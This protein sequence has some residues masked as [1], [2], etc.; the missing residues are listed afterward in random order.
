MPDAP[1]LVEPPAEMFRV[2]RL[3]PALRYSRINAEDAAKDR[4]G[5]RFDVPGG[6][7]L[8]AATHARGGLAETL[9]NFR[10]SASVARRVARTGADAAESVAPEL[11]AAWRANR[12]IRTLRVNDPLP[13]IDIESASTHTYLT[14]H[15]AHVLRSVEL[16]ALDV[17]AVRGPSRRLTRGL[18]T[19]IYQTQSAD[20][21]PLYGGI[22]Y[23]SRLGDYE[24]WAIFE[25]ADD[26]LLSEKRITIDDPDL[27]AVA[28]LYD[29][30]L[31]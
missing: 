14:Q 10:P 31:S 11:D 25:G 9:A 7:V 28:D 21:T 3:S 12:V 8:Y 16:E 5:N 4:G 19:W 2:E 1:V 29:I 30:R 22:R 26:E 13:F 27:V 23:L 15:A 18:A 17:S 6:G 20:G 24:C